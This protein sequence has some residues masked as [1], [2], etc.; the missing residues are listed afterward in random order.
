MEPILK[1][2]AEKFL[3]ESM[4][5]V[6]TWLPTAGITPGRKQFIHSAA[7]PFVSS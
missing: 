7:E 5:K 1:L 3:K 2:R 4:A 6:A